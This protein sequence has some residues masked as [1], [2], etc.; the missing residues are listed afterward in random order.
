MFTNTLTSLF[1]DLLA[2]PTENRLPSEQDFQAPD[3]W[4]WVCD[5]KGTFIE[6]SPEVEHVLG[7]PSQNFLDKQL[8]SFA[9]DLHSASSLA[10]TLSQ[11][12]LPVGLRL[13][14]C[15]RSGA[16]V[17]VSMQI[18]PTC[19]S[20]GDQIGL[21]GFAQ[22]LKQPANEQ[23]AESDTHSQAELIHLASAIILDMLGDLRCSSTGIARSRLSRI[24]ARENKHQLSASK[25]ASSAHQPS[26]TADQPSDQEMSED[27][28]VEHRLEWGDKF[29][30]TVEEALFISSNLNRPAGLLGRAQTLIAPKRILKCSYQ[31]V[32]VVLKSDGQRVY[33]SVD[34]PHLIANPTGIYL[35]EFIQDQGLIA[36][37]IDRAVCNPWTT[38]TSYK[39]GEDYMQ[40]PKTGSNGNH[41]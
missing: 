1:N 38:N 14:Y 4:T 6:C 41:K 27:I 18:F 15:T 17:P 8:A 37:D 28:L 12:D 24:I 21:Y 5:E 16:L 39:L 13:D 11:G 32:S 31:W 2:P 22:V 20:A 33:V 26:L 34:Y 23:P 19:S 25:P 40:A 36:S 35:D 3:G 9:L 10:I 30:F 7:I 29:D